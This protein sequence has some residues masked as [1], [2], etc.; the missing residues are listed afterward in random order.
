MK[1]VNLKKKKWDIDEY[2]KKNE[3]LEEEKKYNDIVVENK[4]R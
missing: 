1:Y 3:G 4:I 2:L